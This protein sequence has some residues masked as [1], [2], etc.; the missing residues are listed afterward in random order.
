M[1]FEVKRVEVK[2]NTPCIKEAENFMKCFESS[3]W[4]YASNTK[5]VRVHETVEGENYLIKFTLQKNISLNTFNNII[6]DV[7]NSIRVVCDDINYQ[8][9]V[10]RVKASVKV[11]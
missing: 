1:R 6:N 9:N 7:Q 2:L 8:Y 5:I 11:F 3:L 10:S 4:N